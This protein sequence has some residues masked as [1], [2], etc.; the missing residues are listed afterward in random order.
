MDGREKLQGEFE[1][2]AGV[3][4]VSAET[5]NAAGEFVDD[6]VFGRQLAGAIGIGFG[7]GEIGKFGKWGEGEGLGGAQELGGRGIG[8][9]GNFAVGG[10]LAEVD[11][12]LADAVEEFGTNSRRLIATAVVQGSG[13][14]VLRRMRADGF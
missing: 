7:G 6:G 8:T 12:D 5:G 10:D 13:A 3:F 1:F 2:L 14:M 11:F 4:G 9:A